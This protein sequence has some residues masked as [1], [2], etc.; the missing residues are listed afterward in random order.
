MTR[1]RTISI[2]AL[3][4]L[5]GVAA[6][7]APARRA[8][9]PPAGWTQQP[10][11]M[12]A[13]RPDVT[14][15]SVEAYHPAA[16]AGAPGDPR[17][18]VLYVTRIERKAAPDRRDAIASAEVEEIFAAQR[19]QG[20]GATTEASS[21]RADPAARQLEATLTWRDASIGVVDT[22]RVVVAAD[23]QQVVAVTGQCLLG[24]GAPP[25]LAKACDAALATLDPGIPAAARVPLAMVAE[26]AAVEAPPGPPSMGAAAAP[27]AAPAAAGAPGAPHTPWT[28]PAPARLDDATRIE[29]PPRPPQPPRS[30]DQRPL[31][32][33]LGLVAIALVFWWNRR[34]RER[35]DQDEGQGEGRGDAGAGGS[36]RGG[37]DDDDDDL[38]AAAEQPDPPDPP[39][40]PAQKEQKDA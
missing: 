1:V 40:P 39:D 2:L 27:G 19:R 20:A 29:L 22:S 15:M 4:G 16:A 25:A 32:L 33:G 11:K 7:Q 28:G 31:Y 26:P 5:A 30:A 6:A 8:V 3:C 24:A 17:P 37:G 35:L 23:A 13:P 18:A 9:T 12:A 36:P 21:R 14:S 10:V 38:H 34:R